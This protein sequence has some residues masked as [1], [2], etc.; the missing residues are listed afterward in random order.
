VLER[1]FYPPEDSGAHRCPLLSR[2]SPKKL[3]GSPTVAMH[4][5]PKPWSPK[6]LR[7]PAQGEQV[8]Q[9]FLPS[10][11]RPLRGTD[12]A[13]IVPAPQHGVGSLESSLNQHQP[14]GHQ[15][16]GDE[17]VRVYRDYGALMALLPLRPG[18]QAQ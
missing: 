7:L 12:T 6:D 4:E 14:A 13:Q 9:D 18:R 3:L 2:V 8:P 10:A 1:F 11:A 5:V 16:G 15:P 17:A